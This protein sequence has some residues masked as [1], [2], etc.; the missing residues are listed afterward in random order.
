MLLT[1][2]FEYNFIIDIFME[3]HVILCNNY[4]EC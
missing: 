1:R 3:N 2:E 4:E